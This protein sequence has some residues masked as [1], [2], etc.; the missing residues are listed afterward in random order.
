ME[1]EVR[2]FQQAQQRAQI[3]FSLEAQSAIA[4]LTG[5]MLMNT[6]L[7]GDETSSEKVPRSVRRPRGRPPKK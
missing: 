7:F 5:Q 6:N 1:Q 3:G 2:T 4:Q